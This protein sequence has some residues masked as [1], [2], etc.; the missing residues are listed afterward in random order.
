MKEQDRRRTGPATSHEKLG[1]PA[2]P[3]SKERSGS[4]QNS[5]FGLQRTVGNQ[6][7]AS[8]FASGAI[9]AKLRVSQPGD[10]DELEADRVADQVVSPAASYAAPGTIHRKCDCPAGSK[11][12][13]DC[14]VEEVEQTKGIH[15]K[16]TKP[17]QQEQSVRDDFLQSLG[18]GQPLDTTVRKSM[19]SRF[20]RNFEDV[21][22][23][24]DAKAS[25]SAHSINARAYTA[26]RDVVF[27]SQEYTPHT[28]AGKKLLAHELAHVAQ[29]PSTGMNRGSA[30]AS[31]TH[32]VQRQTPPA[33]APPP[34]PSWLQGVKITRHVSGNIYEI[35]LTSYGPTEVGP[36]S[37]LSA[38]LA[39]QGR[40][41]KEQAH[42]IVGTEHLRDV[43]A[44]YNEANAPCVA[45]ENGTHNA[46]STRITSV[47]NELGGRRG[48]RPVVSRLEI[49][50]LYREVY[51]LDTQFKELSTISNN[52]LGTSSPK[53]PSSG[54]T[55]KGGA[56]TPK[57]S[58]TE[59]EPVTT[60][61][62]SAPVPVPKEQTPPVKSTGT[63]TAA[64]IL[65]S[66]NAVAQLKLE[67]AES[68]R[69]SQRI[70]LYSAAFG[71]LLQALTLLDTI[72]DA[73]KM[74]TEG[75][76]LGPAQRQAEKIDS[77]S[78]EAVHSSESLA[79]SMS[80]FSAVAN[81]EKAQQTGNT[82]SLF[83]LSNSLNELSTYLYGSINNFTR[84]SR[85]L[86]AR[87]RAILVMR[88]FYERLVSVP[89]GIDTAANAQAFAMYESLEKLHGAVNSAAQNYATAA[90]NLSTYAD[91][92]SGL[93]S[94]ASRTAWQILLARLVKAQAEKTADPPLPPP[95]AP[96]QAPGLK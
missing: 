80:L 38:Y 36:Y 12:C 18:P 68:V 64:E 8:L 37:E 71:A 86:D 92:F 20:G 15:R 27:A 43:H 46:V 55:G 63:A 84:L 82:D 67:A 54:G 90:T 11:S 31:A 28:P 60:P 48:G 49:A 66:E 65:E 10:A 21:R 29:Q 88:D 30:L 3:D 74:G 7:V 76:V 14:E 17:S 79:E 16:S 72:S 13:P 96:P 53:T 89:M 47:Q 83:A 42:H 61:Q 6:A 45:L 77:Q 9:Q 94:Q 75:T 1:I 33:G 2:R 51:T 24:T 62:K 19:E 4:G 69:L 41:S 52:V 34:P 50:G 56:G 87:A 70:Q 35:N 22:V 44:S 39:A 25:A 95:S 93:A 40:S 32:G 57:P 26:G 23:H 73:L 58:S 85:E 78:Q 5:A 59:P 81:V 91:W